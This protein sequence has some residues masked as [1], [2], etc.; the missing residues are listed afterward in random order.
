MLLHTATPEGIRLTESQ[1]Q[2]FVDAANRAFGLLPEE[3]AKTYLASPASSR[4]HQN[5]AGGLLE[6]CW[7]M[8]LWLYSRTL[9]CGGSVN[10][11]VE[12]CARIALFHDLCKVG[13]YTIGA[14]GAYHSDKEMYKHHAALSIQR[15]QEFGITLS[16]TE[17]VAILLHMA[18]AWWNTED[19][20]L[21]TDSDREWIARRF[22]VLS[23]VQW[24]DMKAC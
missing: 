6:H 11:T 1:I 17:K 7:A 22:D 15:C 20:D 23:A 13:L 19:E 16:Q 8:G 9:V 21:L 24:S 12:E 14:D 4:F 10:L 2:A 5:Y 3:F 18:G